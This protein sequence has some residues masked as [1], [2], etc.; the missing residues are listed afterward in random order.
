MGVLDVQ[1]LDNPSPPGG[2]KGDLK[3]CNF[4]A[5]NVGG[6]N[7]PA[8]WR[9]EGESEA[10]IYEKMANGGPGDLHEVKLK[11]HGFIE[12]DGHRMTWLVLSA[13]GWERL[14]FQSARR[15]DVPEVAI[16]PGG[17]RVDMNCEVRFGIIGEA[18]HAGGKKDKR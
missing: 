4:S 3:L 17:H 14:K 6:A 12:M 16:L 13:A 2:S 7:G 5:T 11:W 9:V 18:A 1:P 10:F 15:A 8:L